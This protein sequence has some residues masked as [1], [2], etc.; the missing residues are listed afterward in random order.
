MQIRFIL[1]ANRA[2]VC[3]IQKNLPKL[4]GYGRNYYLC[5]SNRGYLK[6]VKNE[7]NL[8][9]LRLTY[10]LPVLIRRSYISKTVNYLSIDYIKGS[11]SREQSKI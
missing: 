7:V 2:R 9:T 11:E 6:W 4:C 10:P 5:R 3:A 8:N 1:I